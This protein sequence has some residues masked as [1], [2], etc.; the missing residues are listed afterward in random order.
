MEDKASK[1]HMHVHVHVWKKLCLITDS[2]V[3]V[4]GGDCTRV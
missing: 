4:G 3:K 2:S 1:F